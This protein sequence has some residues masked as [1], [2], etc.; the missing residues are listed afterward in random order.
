MLSFA[1][2]GV[3]VVATCGC[4]GLLVRTERIGLRRGTICVRLAKWI[5]I[6][7]LLLLLLLLSK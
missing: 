1:T 7:L 6:G 3:G 5:G 4:L 2:R